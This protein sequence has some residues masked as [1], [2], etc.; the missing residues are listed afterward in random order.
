MSAT[1]NEA[2]FWSPEPLKRAMICGLPPADGAALGGDAAGAEP[3]FEVTV[4]V[5]PGLVTVTVGA[6]TV[7]A[8]PDPR[9]DDAQADTEAT[10]TTAIAGAS[11]VNFLCRI[12]HVLRD[13]W[14][15]GAGL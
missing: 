12:V 8:A 15:N 13:A 5:G 4:L 3:V 7:A 10:T 9:A 6:G 2:V 11:A 14:R 1:V